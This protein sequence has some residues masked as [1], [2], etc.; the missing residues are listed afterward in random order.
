MPA[1]FIAFVSVHDQA[2]YDAYRRRV[3]PTLEAYGARI[4][5]MTRRF[6]VVEGDLAAERL[7]VIEFPDLATAQRWYASPEYREVMADRVAGTTTIG[8]LVDGVPA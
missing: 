6:E 5:V 1:Y 7:A 3:M 4:R 8:I 2:R